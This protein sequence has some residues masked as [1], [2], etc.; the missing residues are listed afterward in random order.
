MV[1]EWVILVFIGLIVGSLITMLSYRLPQVMEDDF[2]DQLKALSVKRSSCPK[3]D[4]VLPWYRLIPVLSW[5]YSKGRCHACKEPIS[6]RYLLIE[7]IAVAVTVLPFFLHGFS[8]NSVILSVF[9]LWLFLVAVIDFEQ[10]LILDSLSLPLLWVGLLVNI[11]GYGWVS[12]ESAVLG[13]VLGYVSLWAVFKLFKAITGK[14][15]LGYGD[16]KLLGAIGAWVGVMALPYVVL[17]GSVATL[18][19]ALMLNLKTP[20]LGQQKI[21]PLGPGLA[22]GGMVMALFPSAFWIGV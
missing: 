3:C 7:L 13:A 17:V 21:F 20:L 6:V 15:G 8:V 22:L 5:V 16:F 12:I 14:E 19:Y 4:A 1:F 18:L 9:M 2:G 10:F 11:A